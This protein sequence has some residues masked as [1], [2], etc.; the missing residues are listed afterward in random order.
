MLYNKSAALCADT[1]RTVRHSCNLI[2]NLFKP[3]TR[4]ITATAKNADHNIP[5]NPYNKL[6]G[7]M[8]MCNIPNT[9]YRNAGII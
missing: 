2:F 6:G 4:Y 1:M 3:F 9:T 5:G 8:G 7:K